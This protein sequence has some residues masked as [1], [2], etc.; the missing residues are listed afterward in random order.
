MGLDALSSYNKL[1]GTRE[2]SSGLPIK[3]Y[4]M[5]GSRA[6]FCRATYKL[7]VIMS[8]STESLGHGE[9]VGIL[10]LEIQSRDGTK[11]DRIKFSKDPM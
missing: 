7:S 6:P 5:T 2:H 3:A 10:L 11:T 8:R 9:E 4:F 1:I